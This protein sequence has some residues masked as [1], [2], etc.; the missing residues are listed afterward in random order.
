MLDDYLNHPETRLE[1]L[2]EAAEQMKAIGDPRLAKNVRQINELA[3]QAIQKAEQKNQETSVRLYKFAMKQFP[4]E[5]KIPF[6]I[7][8]SRADLPTGHK[9]SDSEE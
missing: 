6:A 4:R 3:W 7:P 9:T 5:K 1:Y 2:D 8:K